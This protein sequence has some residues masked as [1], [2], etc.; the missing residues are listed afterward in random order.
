MRARASRA[1]R[2]PSALGRAWALYHLGKTEEALESFR[3]LE[4]DP[5]DVRA[6]FGDGLCRIRL[7]QPDAAERAFRRV[8]DLRPRYWQALGNLAGLYARTGRLAEARAAY[9]RLLKIHP[10]DERA[11]AWLDQDPG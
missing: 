9:R 6:L 11:R 8:L 1:S 3:A 7:D 2:P 10:G 4:N 5:G